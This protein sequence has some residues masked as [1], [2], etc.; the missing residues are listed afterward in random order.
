MSVVVREPQFADDR[1]YPSGGDALAAKVDGLLDIAAAPAKAIGIVAPHAGYY[2]SGVVA[3]AIY[4][5]VQVPDRIIAVGPN[6][7]GIGARRAIMSQGV[8]RIPCADVQIDHVAAEVVKAHIPSLTEDSVGHSLEH[9]LEVQ[10]P[11]IARRN[12]A[13][14]IVPICTYPMNVDQCRGVGVALA[15]AVRALEGDTL[16]VASS[17]MNHMEPAVIGNRKD[18]LAIDR[19]EAMDPAGLFHTVRSEQI[20]MCGVVPAV[21]MLYAALELGAAQATCVK[22]ND[23]GDA[24]GDKTQVVGYAGMMVV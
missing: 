3:G 18:R 23:S 19:F 11:F 22:Y 2:Y 15:R 21:I 8:W 5:A 4:G 17:D 9:S 6:H 20:T 10:M 12:P 1:W 13:A 24:C 7:R 14:R 16:I